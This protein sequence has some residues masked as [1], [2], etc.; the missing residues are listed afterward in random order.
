MSN[1]GY[2]CKKLKWNW[3]NCLTDNIKNFLTCRWS[4][5][6]KKTRKRFFL[7]VE[8]FIVITQFEI[9]KCLLSIF[10]RSNICGGRFGRNVQLVP[11]TLEVWSEKVKRK[12]PC[13]WSF[14]YP[15]NSSYKY[16]KKV[17]L[18]PNYN[19]NIFSEIIELQENGG[20][21]GIQ[22]QIPNCTVYIGIAA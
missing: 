3:T 11:K 7:S 19:P 21:G 5:A 9:S 6:L 13:M 18:N 16:V 17:K 1:I 15:I 22:A 14:V 10:M 20:S 8:L 4:P 12:H 2:F